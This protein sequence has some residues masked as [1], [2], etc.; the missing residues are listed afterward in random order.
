MNAKEYSDQFP[1]DGDVQSGFVIMSETDL[2]QV[3]EEYANH[4]HQAQVKNNVTLGNV[5]G[6]DLIAKAE[7][8]LK[9]AKYKIENFNEYDDDFGRGSYFGVKRIVDLIKRHYR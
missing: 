4:Y 7:Q 9:E 1:F 5:S 8:Y 2:V 3:M 6:S